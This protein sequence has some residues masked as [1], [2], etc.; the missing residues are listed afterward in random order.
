MKIPKSI[1]VIYNIIGIGFSIYLSVLYSI[2]VN[3][4]TDN[5]KNFYIYLESNDKRYIGYY[6]NVFLSLNE[7]K[8]YQLKNFTF[9]NYDLFCFCKNSPNFRMFD[10]NLCFTSKECDS[11]I[12]ITP[13]NYK[14]NYLSIW[15]KKNYMITDRNIIFFQGIN[16]YTKK[17]DINFN[18]KKCGFLIDL[19]IDFCIKEN[20]MCPF[21]DTDTNFYLTNLTSDIILLFEDKNLK[22]DNIYEISDFLPEIYILNKKKTQNI[23]YEKFDSIE[24]Y[25][26]A[27]D[28]NINYL[29]EKIYNNN[30]IVNI[31]LSLLK[32]N[33]KKDI[34]INRT[35]FYETKKLQIYMSH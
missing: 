9:N 21:K 13:E 30:K 17:C 16:N 24:L 12:R 22:I 15:N 3:Y 5:N 11:N 28:N 35:F 20:E 18:Y 14:V 1:T 26:F 7:G 32:V 29:K 4:V 27:F 10:L 33:M 6:P 23:T 34:K 25:Q 19:K 8:N 2:N 31:D